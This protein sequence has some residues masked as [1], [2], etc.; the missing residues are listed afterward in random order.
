MKS[1]SKREEVGKWENVYITRYT[2]EFVLILSSK[3]RKLWTHLGQS[4]WYGENSIKETKSNLIWSQIYDDD[5]RER[6]VVEAKFGRTNPYQTLLVMY[7]TA[8][9]SRSWILKR[10]SC[11]KWQNL[12]SPYII[13]LL[14]WWIYICKTLFHASVIDDIVGI[15]QT[16]TT[17]PHLQTPFHRSALW[18][19]T[20]MARPK[21]NSKTT[22]C[23]QLLPKRSVLE[24]GVSVVPLDINFCNCFMGLWASTIFNAC[25]MLTYQ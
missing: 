1:K 3:M 8:T 21:R 25:I 22:C 7:E 18:N 10:F 23:I 13:S 20:P 4:V 9:M 16:V 5:D 2:L 11:I 6:L 12:L 24:D 17:H 19:T 14:T 15:W